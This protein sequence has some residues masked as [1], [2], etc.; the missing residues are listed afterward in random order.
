MKTKRRQ[1]AQWRG[2]F[3]ALLSWFISAALLQAQ[4]TGGTISGRVFNPVTGEYVRNAEVR[5]QGSQQLVTTGSDGS[6]RI[7]NVPPGAA[8]IT[9]TYTGY[10]TAT[11]S[12]SV[13]A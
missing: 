5:L 3:A 4:G 1:I 8:T 9:V 2:C 11:E 6:F 10:D 13:S 12:V 7:D